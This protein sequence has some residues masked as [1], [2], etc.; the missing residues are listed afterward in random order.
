[1]DGE[2][3]QYLE[4]MEQRLMKGMEERITAAVTASEERLVERI[5][6]T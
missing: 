3:K 5:R 6:D 1:M 4:A 2:L